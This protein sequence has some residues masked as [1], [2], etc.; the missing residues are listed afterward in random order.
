MGRDNCKGGRGGLLK[1]IVTLCRDLCKN[2]WTNRDAV[3]VMDS[4]GPRKHVLDGD[5]IHD[6]KGQLWERTCPGMPDDTA[7]SYTKVAEPIDLLFRL[8]TQVGWRKHKLNHI[9]QMAPMCPPRSPSQLLL[10]TCLAFYIWGAHWRRL[11]N[12]TEP[13]MCSL[14]SNYFDY[15]LKILIRMTL[16]AGALSTSEGGDSMTSSMILH[17][18]NSHWCSLAKQARFLGDRL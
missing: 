5:Q 18:S 14:M 11:V 10:S 12:M 4:D 7:V 17:H 15:L 13:S 2:G 1:R 9:F 3:W 16:A 8:W 6:T